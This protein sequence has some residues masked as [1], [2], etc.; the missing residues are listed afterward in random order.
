[1]RNSRK[2]VNPSINGSRNISTSI[3]NIPDEPIVGSLTGVNTASTNISISGIN[4][5]VPIAFTTSNGTFSASHTL[6]F[7]RNNRL[8][9]TVT[10]ASR[11]SSN[12]F[13][14]E[15]FNDNDTLTI[16]ANTNQTVT[17]TLNIKSINISI[18][19]TVNDGILIPINVSITAI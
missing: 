10:L 8:I 19:N 7:Y 1:M 2:Y 4:T 3:D 16:I 6:E 5:S 12:R 15:Q 13:L 14:S 17:Y 11:M 9:D 18:I